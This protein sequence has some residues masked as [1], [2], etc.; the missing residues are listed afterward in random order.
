[1]RRMIRNLAV[2]FPHGGFK[3]TDVPQSEGDALIWLY[4]N[5]NGPNWTNNTNWLQ[6]HTVGNWFGVTVAGGH[7][8]VV[9]L[10]TNNLIGNIGAFPVHNLPSL[11]TLYFHSNAGLS[12]N[13]GGWALP[14]TLRFLH[15]FITSLSGNIGGWALPAALTQMGLYNTGVSGDI[16]GWTLPASLVWLYL[17]NTSLSGDI[18]GWTLPTSLIYLHIYSTSLSGTPDISGNTGMRDYRFDACALIQANVDAI[19][20]SVYNRRMAFIFATPALKIGGSDAAPSGLYQAACPPTTGKEYAYEL[21]ND[22]CLDGFNKW[23]VAF[24]A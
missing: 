22:S 6:T 11:T 20:L 15:L 10:N 1:M 2:V 16:G 13:I 23:T 5:T 8:T 21:V 14:A 7:V 19:L 4:K 9:N 24:T 12:G 3:V 18:G 17:Y